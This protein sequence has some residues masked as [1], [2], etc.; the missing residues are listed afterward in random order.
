MIKRLIIVLLALIVVFGGI[1]GWKYFIGMKMAEMFSRPHPPAV[2]SSATVEQQDWQPYLRAVGSVV[3]HRGVYVSNQLDG[4]VRD[5]DFQSGQTV[6]KDDVLV[7]LDD[8]VDRA[9]LAGLVADQQLA[10]V[11]F[12]RQA[13]LIKQ[14]STSQADYDRAKASLDKAKALV[15]AQ[16]ARIDKLA[17]RAPFSGVLGIRQVDL[18]QY[19]KAGSQIVSLQA[20]DPIYVDFSLPERYLSQ[21]AEKQQVLVQVP[22]YPGRTFDG[23]ISVVSAKV[24]QATRNVQVRATLVNPD[25]VLR[26]GMFA[27][28][29][30]AL[31]ARSNVLT[32]PR[33]AITYN[34]Y[35][36]SVFLI[37]HKDGKLVVQ[38]KQVETG[39]T[40]DGRVEITKGLKLGDQVVA[41]GQVKLRNGQPVKIDNSVKLD[42]KADQP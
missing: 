27:E 5:I 40:R 42:R 20:L 3:A 37:E 22:A 25:Q 32:V 30:V 41:A 24:D 18:G 38:R 2:V 34:P 19:L 12:R 31:P 9:Q 33:T 26:P 15:A 14:K 23:G 36:D 6:Q 35:G 13:R 10:E 1:F 16:R 7:Q 29:R 8:S 4:Q 11:E 28:V 39:D 17:V 21:L